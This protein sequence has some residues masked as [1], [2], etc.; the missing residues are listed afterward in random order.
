MNALWWTCRINPIPRIKIQI[1]E[2]ALTPSLLLL[3]L[4]SLLQPEKSLAGKA[5]AIPLA[6]EAV[7]NTVGNTPARSEKSDRLLVK[8][9]VVRVLRVLRVNQRV[10]LS[11]NTEVAVLGVPLSYNYRDMD[12]EL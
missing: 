9:L 10:I 1:K 6:N 8:G 5:T 11:G 4:K 3:F 2:I 7:T 12:E